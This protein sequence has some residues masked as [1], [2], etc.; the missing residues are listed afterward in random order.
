MIEILILV[1]VDFFPL[2]RLDE[3]LATAIIVPIQ[4]ADTG[5]IRPFFC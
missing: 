5:P 2:Q 3:A 1:G 4:P